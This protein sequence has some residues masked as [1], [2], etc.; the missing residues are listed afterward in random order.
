MIKTSVMKELR[1]SSLIMLRKPA[2]TCRKAELTLFFSIR[3]FFHEYH[4]SQGSRGRGRLFL[5]SSLRLPPTLQ[6]IRH[7]PGYCCRELTSVHSWQPDSNQKPFAKH[8]ATSPLKFALSTLIADAVRSTLK[9]R[10]ALGSISLVLLNLNKRFI[11]LM[12]K[13]LPPVFT[14]LTFIF[15]L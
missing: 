9:T 1:R 13:L 11:F 15:S 2:L 10:V 5:N 6:T 14:Q 7:Y 12:F 4:D 8:W 3:V